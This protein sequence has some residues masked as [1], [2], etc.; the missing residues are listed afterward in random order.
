[1]DTDQILNAQ[2]AAEFLGAHIETIRRLARRGGI[3][4]FKV[5]KDWRFSKKDLREWVTNQGMHRM[6]NSVLVVDD[7]VSIAKLI[8]R[9]I[10]PLG[11]RVVAARDG[12]EGLREVAVQKI[13]LVLL[14]LK[15]PGMNGAEFI[16]RF[17]AR[18]EN[19]PVV[20]VTGYPE[21]ELMRQAMQFGPLMLLQKPIDQESLISTVR[22]ALPG[23][24]NGGGAA[25]ER[26]AG[27][28]TA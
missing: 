22:L 26:N 5:G 8:R 19:T 9:I 23:Q 11:Y 4:A 13:D 17:R 24:S 15:M 2:E 27:R 18:Q 21:S 25:S 16:Q 7:E 10:G 6:Q 28:G 3:P 20:I 12:Q 14:D 1:M